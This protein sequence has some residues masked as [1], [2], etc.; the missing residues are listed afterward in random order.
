MTVDFVHAGVFVPAF[1]PAEDSEEFTFS[2]LSN[3]ATRLAYWDKEAY[4]KELTVSSGSSKQLAASGESQVKSA[5]DMAAAAAEGEGL[6]QLGKEGEAK[7]KK[8][9]AEAASA[10]TKT[11]KVRAALVCEKWML[12][13]EIDC[14]S[15][16]AILE[17]SSR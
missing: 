14:A 16:S 8:R 9:K 7:A 10:A 13:Q 17:Q 3:T 5:A 4:V 6:V 2:P 15:T 1:N 12:K 11:K